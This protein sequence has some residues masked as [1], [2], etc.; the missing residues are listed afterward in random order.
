MHWRIPILATLL[1][2]CEFCAP[3]HADLLDRLNQLRFKDCRPNAS[4]VPVLRRN[5]GLDAVALEWSKGGRLAEALARTSY[6]SSKLASMEVKGSAQEAQIVATLRQSYCNILTDPRYSEVGLFRRDAGTWIVVA[7]VAAFPS[8][9]DT[10]AISSHLLELINQARSEPRTCGAIKFSAATP[11]RAS[12]S[13]NEAALTHAVDMAQHQ[14]FQHEG[15]DGSSPGA[16]ATRAGYSWSRVG[17]N[18]AVGVLNAEEAVKGWLA[19]PGHCANIMQPLFT[20]MGVGYA[21]TSNA[22]PNIYWSQVLARPRS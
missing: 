13:L 9:N 7:A 8:P 10:A 22:K 5:K 6:Y 19:S 21:V 14:L 20:E 15:S 12:T 18:I 16:R 17:E 11:L 2:V 4:T 1:G 3:A